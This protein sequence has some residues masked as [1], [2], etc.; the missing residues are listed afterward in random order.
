MSVVAPARLREAILDVLGGSRVREYGN[1]TGHTS[2]GGWDPHGVMHHW[3]ASTGSPRA[4]A[5]LLAYGYTGLPG[6]LCHFSPD[7]YGRAWLIGVGNG[8]HA[9]EGD[10]RVLRAITAGTYDGSFVGTR[11]DRDGNPAFYGLE[12]QYHPSQGR[13]PD[14]QMECG[15]LLAVAIAAAHGWAP[16]DLVAGSNCDHFEWTDRKWDRER[17]DMAGRTR[18]GIVAIMT[19]AAAPKPPTEASVNFPLPAGHWYGPESSHP[20]NHSGYWAADRDEIR[21][22]QNRLGVDLTG[23]YNT[24]TERAVRRFQ[25]GAGLAADGLVG[26]NTWTKLFQEDDMA[27]PAE[28]SH[29]LLWETAID[30]P[31][32]YPVGEGKPSTLDDH[33]LGWYVQSLRRDVGTLN[34]ELAKQRAV[35][36]KLADLL[37]SQSGVTAE[38]FRAILREEVV[39][40]EVSVTEPGQTP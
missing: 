35:M 33:P 5:R 29:H 4:Q 38:Q 3:T 31:L 6:P 24:A 39:S 16:A 32:A 30:D 18:R 25:A 21:L 17:D 36:E 12:Y 1:W 34:K 13:M 15:M 2:P 40:V 22:I 28:Y 26:V 23:R 11:E 10:S 19:G 20:R 27:D 9:G 14:E 37:A 7:R 8:N